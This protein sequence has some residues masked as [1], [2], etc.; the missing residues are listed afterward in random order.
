V[1][2]EEILKH[3]WGYDSFR[4]S[5]KEV[6][7]SILSKQDTLALLP[8]GAGK[9]VCY[10]VPGLLFPGV[11][12]VISPLISLMKDQVDGLLKRNIPATYLAST[13]SQEEQAKR[14][15]SIQHT[16]VKF[17]YVSPEKLKTANF[18]ELAKSLPISQVVIDE[19]HCISLWGTDFRPSY[20][21]IPIFISCLPSRP[22]VAALT[23]TATPSTQQEIVVA[24]RLQKPNV[25]KS[26]F[27]RNI[28]CSIIKTKTIT[29]HDLQLLAYLKNNQRCGIIYTSSRSETERLMFKLNR[30]ANLLHLDKVGCYHAGLSAK[31][32]QLTQQLFIDNQLQILVATT[33]FG[34]GIDKPDIDFV[35]HYHPPATLEGYFQE[36]GR[37][38]RS[39]QHAAAILLFNTNHLNIHYGLLS[40]SKHSKPIKMLED[41]KVFISAH[42]CRMQIIL[43]YFGEN[44][45][46]CGMCD[47]CIKQP[48]ILEQT[49]TK[50]SVLINQCITWRN[51]IA[52]KC[53][54]P[55]ETV[56][57]AIQIAYLIILQPRSKA[58]LTLIPG[59]GK[60]WVAIW[61]DSFLSHEWYNTDASSIHY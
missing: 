38:G 58:D 27:K 41:V 30:L 4:L 56:L 52:K 18:V 16:H 20:L 44:T 42:H 47:V 48:S 6:A 43:Q 51:M 32:R 13:L 34:M 49:I 17:I 45:E 37:A 5:Q 29:E 21:E 26:S 19:S 22:V 55:A 35:L 33:A 15:Q 36:I 25:F 39:G 14:I 8:T 53:R 60:G 50:N 10:Q 3:Y 40:K 28:A 61:A 7:D 54:V 59:I 12:I 31:E 24:L 46:V 1:T 23:A 11:T 2:P 57:S 9:S